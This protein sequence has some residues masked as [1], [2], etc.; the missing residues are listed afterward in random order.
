MFFKNNTITGLVEKP[1]V[2]TMA[3]PT[4][5]NHLINGHQ[6]IEVFPNPVS[7]LANIQI[8]LL[9]N[10]TLSIQVTDAFGREVWQS[11][12][13]GKAGTNQVEWKITSDIP[14]GWYA[15]TVKGKNGL[16]ISKIE[17]IK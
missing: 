6:Q 14:S 3:T 17:V 15:I 8:K 5:L 16:R 4:A 1:F 12:F 13:D 11:D 9:E 10:E 2:F 7:E